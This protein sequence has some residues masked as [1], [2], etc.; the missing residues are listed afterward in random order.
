MNFINAY[1]V[2]AQNA[3]MK[4]KVIG[5]AIGSLDKL[6]L[7]SND[8]DPEYVL[9]TYGNNWQAVFHKIKEKLKPRGKVRIAP[10]SIWPRYC[11]T[12]LS[13]ACFIDQF[14][15]ANEFYRWIDS[16]DHDERSRAAL[17]LILDHEIYG[18]GF[19]LS[20]DFL[21][22]LGYVNYP[23]PDAHLRKIFTSLGLCQERVDNYNLFKAIVRV[24]NNAN[25][26]PYAVDKIFW[27]IGS[28]KFYADPSIGFIGSHQEDFINFARQKISEESEAAISDK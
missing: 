14:D 3:N 6:A 2:S 19:A 12:I 28:G 5:D 25:I 8:F 16:F 22:E 24:A 7:I 18:F 1:Y 11:R 21:K 27:L 15:S 10:E 9:K 4:P 23:K 26:T 13:A 20:C 17:P